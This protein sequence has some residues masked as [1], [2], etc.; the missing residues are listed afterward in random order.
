[1]ATTKKEESEVKKVTKKIAGKAVNKIKEVIE[2]KEEKIVEGEEVTKKEVVK[3]DIYE[4]VSV[5]PEMITTVDKMDLEKQSYDVL[6]E[7]GRSVTEIKTFVQ[8]T[9]GRLG[10]AVTVKY[11]DLTQYAKDINYKYETLQQ[12]MNVYRK[13][14]RDNPN[15]HPDQYMGSVPWG[16][17]QIVASSTDKPE[18]LLNE[19]QDKGIHS[20]KDAYRAIKEAETGKIIPPKPRAKYVWNA[21]KEKYTFTFDQRDID[22]IDWDD[23]VKAHERNWLKK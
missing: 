11:G 20:Q 22:V 18:K 7:M 3:R 4:A 6:V 2:P 19:L 16:M 23:F 15:F 21:E 8:W 13:F 12:Y 17:L 10:D 5:Q 9:L 14:T 1:M